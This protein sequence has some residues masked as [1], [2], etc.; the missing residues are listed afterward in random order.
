MRTQNHSY[1][2]LIAA[3]LFS[4]TTT[5][6]T[7]AVISQATGPTVA[8]TSAETEVQETL[9]RYARAWY[10]GNASLMAE[11]LHPEY[12]RATV[13]R[14]PARTD[15]IDVNS[16]LALI[17]MTDRGFGRLVQP[18]ARKHEI[19]N[20]KVD[21]GHASAVLKLADRTEMVNLARWNNLW[22]V[23]QVLTERIEP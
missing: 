2:N 7:S 6:A 20:V 21:G 23:V 22:R 11:Q 8:G 10:E 19:S 1:S 17:D 18:S 16:G 5:V 13:R 9:Q 3:F 4:V 15:A 14:N 12:T